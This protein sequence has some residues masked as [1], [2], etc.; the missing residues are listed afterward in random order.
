MILEKQNTTSLHR[1]PL[2]DDRKPT[3]FENWQ[4]K[5]KKKSNIYP[6]FWNQ[7]IPM[8][9]HIMRESVPCKILQLMNDEG[10]ND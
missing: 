10:T 5:V 2:E 9:D 3:Y 1:S 6:I 8:T 7:N 4:I